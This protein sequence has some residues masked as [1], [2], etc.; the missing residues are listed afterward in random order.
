MNNNKKESLRGGIGALHQNS[1]SMGDF[2]GLSGSKE[3]VGDFSTS[4]NIKGDY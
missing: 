4:L 2:G 1:N 3:V